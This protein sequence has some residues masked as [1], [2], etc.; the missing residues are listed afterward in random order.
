MTRAGIPFA[1]LFGERA[2][3]S[4]ARH[5]VSPDADG[6]WAKGALG[7]TIPS[8]ARPRQKYR[9]LRFGAKRRILRARHTKARWWRPWTTGNWQR[10]FAASRGPSRT[11]TG[12]T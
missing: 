3:D 10:C 6:T 12:V 7:L 11:C 5:L 2:A 4:A 9:F 1:R 8:R